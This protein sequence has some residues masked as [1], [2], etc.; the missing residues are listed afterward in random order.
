MLESGFKPETLNQ[1]VVDDKERKGL[2]NPT[3]AYM[4]GVVT[5]EEETRMLDAAT[6]N[7][8]KGGAVRPGLMYIM[9]TYRGAGLG[10]LR[11]AFHEGMGHALEYL[12]KEKE[13]FTAEGYGYVEVPSMTAEY[14]LRDAEMLHDKAV[15]VAGHKPSVGDFRT[16]IRNYEKNQSLNLL[17]RAGSALYDLDLW[18]YDYTA[19]G[20]K[21]YIERA[22]EVFADVE[23]RTGLPP[24]ADAPVPAFYANMATTHFTSGN[25]RNIGYSY[26]SLGSEMMAQYISRE[27]EARTG[28][29]GWYKQPGLAD[30][31]AETW[32]KVA[33]KTP[34]PGN[35]E[36]VTGRKFDMKKI[37]ADLTDCEDLLQ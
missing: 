15:E 24:M 1:I 4:A 20:A 16:W 7:F 21:N 11:T 33:W 3:M 23:A 18:D 35:I 30:L 37:L 5:P 28:R 31:I 10:D 17:A 26:A 36:R 32:Y 34:F 19:P 12:L 9:Q 22:E 8:V 2:K 14:F 6:L 29:A 25:V 27:L 13:E